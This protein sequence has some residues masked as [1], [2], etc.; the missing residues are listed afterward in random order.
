ME[1]ANDPDKTSKYG[2]VLTK[3]PELTEAMLK[4]YQRKEVEVQQSLGE[5]SGDHLAGRKLTSRNKA[6]F[7]FRKVTKEHVK[8]KSRRWTARSL[9]ATMGSPMDS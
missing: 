1:E 8:N 3:G 9:S 2:K 6:K 4:Q 5:P 7:A